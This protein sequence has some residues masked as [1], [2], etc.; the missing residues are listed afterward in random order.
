M[1]AT[2]AVERLR[3]VIRRQHKALSTE[4]CYIF[5]LRRYMAALH[6]MPANLPS[7]KKLEQFLTERLAARRGGHT[8]DSVLL[9]IKSC[10]C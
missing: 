5:W 9:L 1:N 7:E 3:Q 2:Q 8:R 6:R 4:D 10:L